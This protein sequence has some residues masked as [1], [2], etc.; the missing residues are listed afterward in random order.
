MGR[1]CANVQCKIS[2]TVLAPAVEGSSLLEALLT[3]SGILGNGLVSSLVA[4][5]TRCSRGALRDTVK[6]SRAYLH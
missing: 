6:R 1:L 5:L 2:A 4:K 3:R